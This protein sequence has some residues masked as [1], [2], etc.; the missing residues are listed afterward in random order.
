MEGKIKYLKKKSN[1]IL[2]FYGLYDKNH[3]NAPK[4]NVLGK[5]ISN[6]L[7]LFAINK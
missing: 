1:K 6:M 4:I 5:S 7:S 3:H 2:K